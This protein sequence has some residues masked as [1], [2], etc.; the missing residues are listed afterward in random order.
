MAKCLKTLRPSRYFQVFIQHPE[1]NTYHSVAKFSQEAKLKKGQAYFAT[2]LTCFFRYFR[3]VIVF[4]GDLLRENK[5]VP[6]FMTSLHSMMMPVLSE[7]NNC[8]QQTEK[9]AMALTLYVSV[10]RCPCRPVS[11]NQKIIHFIFAAQTIC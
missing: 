5:S 1:T 11:C 9:S 7:P 8:I 6:F 2:P 3:S 4:L 10:G